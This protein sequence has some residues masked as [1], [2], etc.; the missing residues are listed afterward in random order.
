M[1]KPG[2]LRFKAAT[3]LTTEKKDVFQQQQQ[4]VV[5]VFLVR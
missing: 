2:Q 4:F 5:V 1:Y 3:E